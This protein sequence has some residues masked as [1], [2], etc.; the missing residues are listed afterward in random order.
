[1]V[2]RFVAAVEAHEG[3][4]AG[5]RLD[6]D[7]VH[8]CPECEPFPPRPVLVRRVVPGC[9]EAWCRRCAFLTDTG[10]VAQ[11]GSWER[12]LVRAGE[13][14]REVHGAALRAADPEPPAGSRVRDDCG[15]VWVND[16]FRPACWVRPDL[17][18]EG[19][20]DPETWTKIAGNYGPVTVVEWGEGE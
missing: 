17:V 14:L 20:H 7:G 18:A 15:A 3:H 11:V 8:R 19:V 2:A 13:H 16:G 6:W 9:W 12:A 5:W 4:R 10:L 1:M